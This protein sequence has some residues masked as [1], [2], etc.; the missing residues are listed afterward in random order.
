MSQIAQLII[1]A[2]R[3]AAAAQAQAGQIWGQ[4][5]DR[6]GQIPGQVV[7]QFNQAQQQKQQL[8]LQQER[9]T[10]LNTATDQENKLRGLQIQGAETAQHTQTALDGIWGSGIIREDG[11][12]DRDKA[13]KAAT[14]AGMP[15]LVPAIIDQANRW[16]ASAADLKDKQTKAQ[17]A[18]LQLNATKQDQLGLNSETIAK[19]GYDVGTF[20]TFVAGAAKAGL[21]DKDQANE[22]VTQAQQNPAIVKQTVDGWI[23]ASKSAQAQ[24]AANRVKLG[25]GETLTD[26]TPGQPPAVIATGGTEPPTGPEL[27][28]AAQ[29]LYAK[30]ASGVA[31][32]PAETYALKGYEERKR[33]VSD[34]ALVASNARLASTQN[35]QNAIQTKAQKFAATEAARKALEKVN[36]DYATAK[37]SADTLRDVIDAAKTGNVVAGSLQSLEATMAAIRAQGLN[38]INTAEI[39]ATGNAGSMFQN[40]EGWLGKKVEGQPVPASVQK[41]M[42][43]FADILEKA[44]YRKYH[45]SHTGI[46]QLYETSI[47]ETLPAPTSY[48]PAE[49]TPGLQGVEKRK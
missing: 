13:T 11:T 24:R 5:A 8:Q 34:P 45:A 16:D 1:E 21:L 18:A 42:Q 41:D 38:R 26:I 7:N 35:Q 39:G 43:E 32:T 3:N 47:P 2:G 9:E 14:T 17:E 10:R 12:I 37:T 15:H 48:T 27:D 36:S 28:A 40:I 25:K 46:N 23:Q 4:T 19:N 20:Q 49:I 31:L 6:L 44:A 22:L 30:Q 33:V 29:A